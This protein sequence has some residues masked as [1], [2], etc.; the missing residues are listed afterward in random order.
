MRTR[1]ITSEHLTGPAGGGGRRPSA[2]L[3]ALRL[4]VA[5]A[6]ATLAWVAKLLGWFIV[7]GCVAS[8][9]AASGLPAPYDWPPRPRRIRWRRATDTLL[10][11][12][13]AT[14]S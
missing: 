12:I 14:L 9:S 2:K 10:A 7:S 5:D 1:T 6:A 3:H 13:E 8:G 4:G 11:E